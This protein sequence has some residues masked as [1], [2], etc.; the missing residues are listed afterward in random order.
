MRA[1]SE[2]SRREKHPRASRPYGRRADLRAA[3]CALALLA[4]SSQGLAGDVTGLKGL[5][6]E[7]QTLLTWPEDGSTEGEWYKLEWREDGGFRN[8]GKPTRSV[9]LVR[10]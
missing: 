1:Q 6:R 10:L 2:Q 9:G 7:A 4:W 8:G 5:H 3:W